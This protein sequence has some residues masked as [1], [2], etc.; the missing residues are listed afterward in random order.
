[1]STR[2]VGIHGTL[3]PVW[4][5]EYNNQRMHQGKRCQGRTP[6]QTFLH[7]KKAVKEKTTA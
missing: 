4:L 2:P 3:R 5:W 7:G 1:M 6:T